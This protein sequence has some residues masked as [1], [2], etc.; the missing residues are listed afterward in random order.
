MEN[1]K[2]YLAFISYKRED[3]KWAKWLQYKLEHYHIPTEV[4]KTHSN[5]PALVRPIFKDT[6]DLSGGVLEKAINEALELSR[7][8]IV[9]CSPRAAKSLWVCKEVQKFIELGKEEYIIPFIVDGTP[10]SNDETECFPAA[11][12]MLSGERELLGININENGQDSAAVKV[13]ARMFN[14]GFDIL[15]QRY[16]REQRQKLYRVAAAIFAFVLFL[17]FVIAYIWRSNVQLEEQ[18]KEITRQNYQ[19]QNDSVLMAQHLNRIQKDSIMLSM[20]K[21]SIIQQKQNLLEANVTLRR[22]NSELIR[23]T[24]AALMNQ[25]VAVAPQ[26]IKYTDNGDSYLGRLLSLEILPKKL[27]FK[28]RPLTIEAEHALRH[29]NLSNNS[30]MIGHTQEVNCI[31]ITSDDKY[32]ASG[33]DDNTVIIWD[34]NNANKL[35]E[36]K[37]HKDKI[38]SVKYSN[39]DRYLLSASLDGTIIIW[40]TRDYSIKHKYTSGHTYEI[41]EAIFGPQSNIISGDW[42]GNIVVRDIATGKVLH[43]IK[44]HDRGHL[45]ISLSNDNQFL[46]SYSSSQKYPMKVWDTNGYGII[47]KYPIEE[48]CRIDKAIFSPD[49]KLLL[50][51]LGAGKMK[52]YKTSDW[53][54]QSDHSIDLLGCQSACFSPDGKTIALGS[55]YGHD[56]T[57]LGTERLDTLGTYDCEDKVRSCLFSHDGRFL[58]ACD[59]KKNIYSWDLNY[60][61]PYKCIF[62]LKDVKRVISNE[63]QYLILS[64]DNCILNYKGDSNLGFKAIASHKMFVD[65]FDIYSLMGRAYY[66]TINNYLVD[67]NDKIINNPLPGASIFA[68][69]KCK[70]SI[71][72]L[73]TNNITFEKWFDYEIQKISISNDATLVA[74]SDTKGKV[75]ILDFRSGTII[76]EFENQNNGLTTMSFNFDNTL[77]LTSDTRNATCLINIR[78]KEKNYFNEHTNSSYSVF[79]EK[80]IFATY[81]GDGTIIL[82]NPV[83]KQKISSNIH[84]LGWHSI[85]NVDFFDNDNRIVAAYSDKIGIWDV[86]TGLPIETFDYPNTSYV[87]M[88]DKTNN[89]VLLADGILR[90]YE[91]PSLQTLIDQ[92]SQKMKGRKLT[93]EERRFNYLIENF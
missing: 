13:V 59:N 9:I 73:R 87:S 60:P 29:S 3:E 74:V 54:E 39:N 83:T 84:G 69:K 15:W 36:L 47:K 64:K 16:Q 86:S 71:Y 7:Y 44:A 68:K 20:Q 45:G 1:N 66:S 6:T 11:L 82:W 27:S 38:V 81:S 53:Q 46:V 19:L 78:T 70:V 80:N 25:A 72:D 55:T 42:G 77:L 63:D 85:K 24:N 32:I 17:L 50:A 14:L 62:Q 33:S 30:K 12:K 2:K 51:T 23:K 52:L 26:A 92:N 76:N 5:L 22:V 41:S 43:S 75:S 93:K 89:L 18:K 49:D 90:V 48:N 67:S 57:I 21:D 40:D 61:F 37:A 8:L 10:F 4:R 56:I 79:G 65:V 31:D 28:D 35:I 91:Y 58:L 34:K 88:S